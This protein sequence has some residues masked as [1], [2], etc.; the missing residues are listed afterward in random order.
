MKNVG[1]FFNVTT[2]RRTLIKRSSGPVL[3]KNNSGVLKIHLLIYLLIHPSGARTP[4]PCLEVKGNLEVS[5]NNWGVSSLHP[6][7]ARDRSQVISLHSKRH[8]F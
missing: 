8:T 5:V 3:K 4:G 7:E 1:D 6:V 2:S